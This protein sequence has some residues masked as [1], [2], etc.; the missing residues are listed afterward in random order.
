MSKKL[1]VFV[2]VN[3]SGEVNKGGVEPVELQSLV[4]YILHSCANLTFKGLMTIGS[5]EESH[6]REKN[7]DFELLRTLKND[8]CDEFKI[9]PTEVELSMG[10]TNDFEMAIEYGSTNVRVGSAIFGARHYSK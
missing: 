7:A 6:S 1:N 10:M 4:E 8:L 3:T 2:Q 5:I 9:K